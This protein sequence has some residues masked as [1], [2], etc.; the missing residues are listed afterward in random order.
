M[1]EQDKLNQQLRDALV[2]IKKLKADLAEERAK[3]REPIAVIG[4]ACHFPG[5]ANTL[6]QYWQLLEQGVD[7]IT[8]IPKDRFDAT[9]FYDPDPYAIGKVNVKQGGFLD[10]IEKFDPTFF[11]I[12][13]AELEN[14]DPQQRLFLEVTYEA[15]ENAGIDVRKL[16]DSDT[17]VYVGLASNDY[18][19]RHFRSGDTNLV[20]PHSYIGTAICANSGR[21]S[22]LMGFQGPSVSLDT[23]CSS[24]LV[25]THLAVQALRNKECSMAL[26]GGVNAILDPEMTI[27]FSTLNGLS[28][29]SRCKTF[30]NEANGFI[31]SE[32]CGIVVLKRLN[33][34]LRDK[35]NILA[36]IKG[37]AVNQDGKSNG[38]TAPSVKAQTKLLQSALRN[39][40]LQPDQ[41]DYIEAHGTGTKIGD[42]I[43]VEA[44]ANVFKKAKSK[45]QPLLLG[46]V[47]SNI[48]HT[49]GAA[50]VAG[51]MKVILALQKGLIPKNLHFKTPNQLVDWNSLPLK[52]VA[53]NTPWKETERIAGVSAFG[54]TGTNAHVV[55]ANAPHTEQEDT[56]NPSDIFVLPLSAKTG[57]AL[58]ALAGKYAD[59]IRSTDERLEDI[60]A[61]AALRRTHWEIREVFVARDKPALIEQLE[62][63]ANYATEAEEIKTFTSDDEISTV[64]VFPG[65]GAQWAGMGKALAAREPVFREALEACNAAI[66]PYVNWDIFEEINK[67][68]GQNRLEE[69]DV[70]QPILVAIGIALAKLWQSKGV[71]PDAVIGHSLGEVAAAY[72]A[73][74]L[75]LEDAAKVICTRSQLMKATSGQG[76]M[77]VTDLT[78]TE[79]GAFLKGMEDK[80]SIAVVNSPSSTVLSGDPEAL[81]SILTKLEAEGRFCR[82]IKVDVASHSPQMDP[83]KAKLRDALTGL[84][85]MDSETRMYSTAL[86]RWVKGSELNA[87]YWENN[88]RSPVQYGAAVRAAMDTGSAVF[89][90]MSPHPVLVTPTQDNITASGKKGRAI[91]S[92]F[93]EKDECVDFLANFGLLHASGYEM[94]WQRIYRQGAY[95]LL[96]NYAWQKERFWLDRPK[97]NFA[98]GSYD[99][100]GKQ[101]FLHWHPYALPEKAETGAL[102]IVGTGNISDKIAAHFSQFVKV[103]RISPNG[104]L[105][106]G[107]HGQIIFCSSVNDAFDVT[108]ALE[109]DLLGI[110]AIL[111]HYNGTGK[112]IPGLVVVT[113]GTQTTGN[114]DPV[115]NPSASLLWGLSRTIE[116]EHPETDIMRYDL[117]DGFG[118][119]EL[120]NLEH[121]LGA[122][123]DKVREIA[124]RGKIAYTPFLQTQNATDTVPVIF[125]PGKAYL[126][127]GGTSGLGLIFAE[128]MAGKGANH[129]VLA[130]RSGEKPETTASI[131]KMQAKG[132]QVSILKADV[133]DLN[134]TQQLIDTIEKNIAPLG[135]IIH[136]AGI[137]DD[138]SLLQLTKAQFSSVMQ[139]KVQGAMNLH[140]ASENKSLDAFILFSS[141]ASMVGLAGQGNYVAANTFLD[142]LAHFRKS[143]GLPALSLNWG[144]IGEVGLA[145]ADIKRGERLKEQGMGTILPKDLPALLDAS[146]GYDGVQLALVDI[147]FVKWAN[148][149]PGA[150]DS[151]LYSK[152][153]PGFTLAAAKTTSKDNGK[154]FGATNL[155]GAVRKVRELVRGHVSAI[156]KMP[157]PKIK[158]DA[159]F[160]SMGIDSLMALQLKNKLQAEFGLNLAVSSIWTY[161]SVE[162]FG[163]FIVAEL[164]LSTQ[165]ATAAP[166]TTEQQSAKADTGKVEREVEE[167][168]LEEL[169][170]QLD[171]KSR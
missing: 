143:K 118:Q 148:A 53:V 4:M 65:Q 70:V 98:S 78:E 82:K 34:A 153:I 122:D 136:A 35:D 40:G 108:T 150:N 154:P 126:V 51:I 60:C 156:T 6:D 119:D 42:P 86:N 47:K 101:Y 157:P 130:S 19:S 93:R 120:N 30:S 63:F 142:Q 117:A 43:E 121:L 31:R 49:E 67:P 163:D 69:I 140:Q 131:V 96:P 160:K 41:V 57:D 24:S 27:Y 2:A 61:M 151:F 165:F 13:P 166:E 162:K 18:A 113:A 71:R 46:S 59:F 84:H 21:I 73:G 10:D 20:N 171:E 48:G 28:E 66:R 95:I 74:M 125:T 159:T 167:M 94:D 91:P 38:F 75:S 29:D 168:S 7:A 135:G 36:V 32:G 110:Q 114:N 62:D 147:D 146:L 127:T 64:F 44:I 88:L 16:V 58:K 155:A 158:D 55:L 79:A 25:A 134:A 68:E 107:E 52:V 5:G 87:S 105:P 12:S 111:Q 50:G 77:G 112:K 45:D 132:A 138:A 133:G 8:D 152:V 144:N 128:W 17:G 14:V 81:D 3:S 90:E 1:Q 15:L 33:D 23:A 169:M 102:L 109:K 39:A 137:L 56:A 92:F 139:A 54:V 123:T 104:Q 149:N 141:F 80:L 26:A 89:I 85:G 100:S 170:R 115:T 11:D 72:I 161:P 99:T 129:I 37:S 76:A 22:Y 164:N 145:A 97:R 116:N 9:A 124:L 106:E 103:D 83:V